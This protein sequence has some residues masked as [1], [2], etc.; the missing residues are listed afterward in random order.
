MVIRHL[1]NIYVRRIFIHFVYA[2][3]GEWTLK[4]KF[5]QKWKNVVI[6]PSPPVLKSV[7][8]RCPKN[9]NISGASQTKSITALS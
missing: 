7:K 1:K 8:P 2:A 5:T 3:I 9:Q 6:V 4:K